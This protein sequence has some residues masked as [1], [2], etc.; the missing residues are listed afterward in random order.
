MLVILMA[1]VIDDLEPSLTELIRAANL[2]VS[3]IL[4]KVGGIQEEN[5]S[6]SLI[7]T[8]TKDLNGSFKERAMGE[9]EFIKVI[10]Y[11]VEYKKKVANVEDAALKEQAVRVF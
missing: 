5:D 6:A 4:L 1:G 2:P 7:D 3:V 8:L 9:R 10:D 11:E